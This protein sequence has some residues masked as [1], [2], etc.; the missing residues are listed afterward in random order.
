MHDFAELAL[1][2]EVISRRIYEEETDQILGLLAETGETIYVKALQSLSL[3]RAAYL[4]GM[5][6]MYEAYLEGR[7]GESG[8]ALVRRTLGD[9]GEQDLLQRFEFMTAAVN[10]LKHGQGRSYE[11]LC[12]RRLE[13]PFSI[14][15]EDG[16][17]DFD[18]GDVSMLVSLVVVDQELADFF[19]AVIM[20]ISDFLTAHTMED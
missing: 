8:W 19:N 13:L 5:C 2:G 14:A 7:Y 4:V 18:E 6:S 12:Q 15:M 1:R 10:V 16:T 17:E 20:E 11:Y 9:A 3:H